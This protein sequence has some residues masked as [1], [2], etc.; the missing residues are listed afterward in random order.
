MWKMSGREKEQE[1]KTIY[2]SEKKIINRIERVH[3]KNDARKEIKKGKEE[4]KKRNY[5]KNECMKINYKRK[6]R[7][8]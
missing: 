2:E 8:Q 5:K 7:M 6:E 3:E 1:K 4:C